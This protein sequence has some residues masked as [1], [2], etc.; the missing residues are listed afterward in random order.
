LRQDSEQ[1]LAEVKADAKNREIEIH[2][3]AQQAAQAAVAL[4]L[5]RF[6]GA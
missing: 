2:A 3:E 5:T 4:E 6:G 1:A